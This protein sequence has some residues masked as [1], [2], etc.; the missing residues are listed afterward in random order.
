MQ[1]LR[2]FTYYVQFTSKLF[3]DVHQENREETKKEDIMGYRK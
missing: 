2:K 1:G 3:E